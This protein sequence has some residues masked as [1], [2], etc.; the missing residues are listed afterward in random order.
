MMPLEWRDEP[1][2]NNKSD[3]K[4]IDGQLIVAFLWPVTGAFDSADPAAGWR[5]QL[6]RLPA[7]ELDEDVPI[8]QLLDSDEWSAI[9][10]SRL[11]QKRHM[12][13]RRL[14]QLAKIAF[15]QATQHQGEDR[16]LGEGFYSV[17]WKLRHAADDAARVFAR[18]RTKLFGRRFKLDP[19]AIPHLT[20]VTHRER[21]LTYQMRDCLVGAGL[22]ATDASVSHAWYCADAF[23]RCGA[24]RRADPIDALAELLARAR[25]S[26]DWP[27][28]DAGNR[29]LQELVRQR[30]GIAEPLPP[31]ALPEPL[32]YQYSTEYPSPKN[33]QRSRR[34]ALRR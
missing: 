33:P 1:F 32:G 16:W 8:P 5:L 30:R 3:N 11:V 7:V 26:R 17:G 34:G 15:G 18:E 6:L 19:T 24:V 25:L 23:E 21:P 27:K 13:V 4:I 12:V 20:Y 14:R 22:R 28:I 10:I 31:A 2:I 9:A 29:E